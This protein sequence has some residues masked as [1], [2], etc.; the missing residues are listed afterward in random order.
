MREFDPVEEAR[1]AARGA[2]ELGPVLSWSA[3]DH[4]RRLPDAEK[5]AWEQAYI[6]ELARLGQPATLVT[7]YGLRP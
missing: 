2:A 1:S 3:T 6:D 5:S 7:P 4:F